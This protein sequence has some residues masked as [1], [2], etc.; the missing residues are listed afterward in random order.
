MIALYQPLSST[1]LCFFQ[2]I[3]VGTGLGL[4]YDS[5]QAASTFFHPKRIWVMVTDALFWLVVLLAYFVFTV[6]LAGGQV[7]GFVLLGMLLGFLAEY[8]LIGWMVR[9]VLVFLFHIAAVLLRGCVRLVRTILRPFGT[10]WVWLQK[11][12]KKIWKKTSI[13]GKKTL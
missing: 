12:L 7:R 6:T 11:N 10:V 13:S 8:E 3:L 4:L 2:A 1:T 5:T 9:A